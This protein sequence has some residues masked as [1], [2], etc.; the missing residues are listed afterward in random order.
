MWADVNN[1]YAQ[2]Y[3]R[4]NCFDVTGHLITVIEC[5][6]GFALHFSKRNDY[7]SAHLRII[8]IQMG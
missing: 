1:I 8:R 3:Y 4:V 2:M 7:C 5:K 6:I